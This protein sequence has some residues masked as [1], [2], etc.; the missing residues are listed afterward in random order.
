MKKKT[1]LPTILMVFCAKGIM[2]IKSTICEDVSHIV[3]FSFLLTYNTDTEAV[4]TIELTKLNYI[5]TVHTNNN[6]NSD[7]FTAKLLL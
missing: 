1:F 4:N 7:I 6:L 5:C 3:M 2:Y